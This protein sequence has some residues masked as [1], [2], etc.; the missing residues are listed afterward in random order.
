[1]RS[2]AS[3][4]LVQPA[5]AAL[6]VTGWLGAAPVPVSAQGA[7]R[8][9][10]SALARERVLRD[11]ERKPSLKQWR[12]LAA[13][14]LRVVSKYPRSG[15]S[16]NALWQ[17]AGVYALAF[18]RFDQES[19]RRQCQETLRRLRREYPASS[20]IARTDEIL[21]V[22][23]TGNAPTSR[24]AKGGSAASPVVP[25]VRRTPAPAPAALPAPTS[26]G[27][28]AVAS[29]ASVKRAEIGNVIRV[30]LEM[31]AEIAYHEE[32][33]GDPAR[34]FFDL[35]S[36]KLGD[37]L[38]EAPI[39]YASDVLKQVRL[40]R[41]PDGST[42]VAMD[43]RGIAGY[44]VFTLYNP[45][46]LVVDFERSA[47]PVVAA[48]LSA[49]EAAVPD[50]RPVASSVIAPPAAPE[51][52]SL[53][54]GASPL[55]VKSAPVA[56]APS[57]TLPAPTAR[58]TDE[59]VEEKKDSRS[60]APLPS[61]PTKPDDAAVPA[62]PSANG[63]GSYSLARQ[64]GL[65]VARVV[66]DPGHGGHDPGAQG[67]GVVEAEL[68]L[69]VARRLEKLLAKEEGIEVEMTR[70]TDVFVPL[71]E[72]TAMANR[73]G[74]DLFLSIHAN[75]SRSSSARGVETYY[76][77]F[78]SNPEAEEVA[79]RENSASSRTL[80]VLPDIIKAIALNNKLDESRD[81]AELVQKSMARRLRAQNARLRSLGVKRAP[82]V[83]LIGAGMPSVLAEV[84][85]VTNKQEASLLKTG[86]YRQRI[87]EALYDGVT[88]YQRSLKKVTAVADGTTR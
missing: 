62:A 39:N 53:P 24:A 25:A 20:L 44:S 29:L 2:C 82:F 54:V 7:E 14:Y 34:V 64:L 59:N 41:R 76:L 81:F 31:D 57:T 75:A 15:Y 12:A 9:Y 73:A 68:V 5:V 78:A 67:Y 71:E 56:T 66:I 17:A 79:A 10:T 3:L 61:E 37:G 60:R 36:V 13:G 26:V 32:R 30:T 65:G 47:P 11:A 85:F 74:A 45:Y 80:H 58:T 86:A 21:E 87:A 55:S 27:D 72:R 8:L 40:G 52:P 63:T 77:N 35:K 43:L 19:D 48:A 83:V 42:R 38:R 50:R 84:S 88:Q 16:D 18:E 69:D 33:V 23:S 51:R 6:L 46:R 22:L 28:G 49:G 4:R 1:M 70:R